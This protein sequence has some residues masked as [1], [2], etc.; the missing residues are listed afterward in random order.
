MKRPTGIDFLVARKEWSE[1]RFDDAL[2][3]A[4][5]DGQVLFRVDRFAITAN[6]ITYALAGD[7]LG[8]WNF[9]PAPEAMGRVPAMG[10]ADVIASRHAD[11]AEGLRCFGF[12]PMSRYLVIEPGSVSRE[13]IMDGAAHRAAL[14]PAYN[15]YSIATADTLYEEAQED[16]L[17]LLRGLFMTSFLADDF[18]ASSDYFGAESVLISSASSKTSIALGFQVRQ[19]GRAR[20]L[21]LTSARNLEFT[22]ALGCYDE[23]LVYDDIRTLN[24]ERPAIFVDMAGNKA[25]LHVIHEHWGAKLGHSCAIGM[26]HWQAGEAPAGPLSG[27]APEF[28][29]APGRIQKRVQDW[30]PAGFQKRLAEAWFRFRTF[31]AGWLEIHRGYGKDALAGVW[32]ATLAGETDPK[33]GNILSLFEAE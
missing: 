24:A 14:A 12:Y 11:V 27:P 28:F 26:T 16:T 8:Y 17:M 33:G 1:T 13:N 4:L 29:F 5:A 18:L 19:S 10:F 32:Q 7:M 21:G 25:I 6:N 15:Q 2:V 30:G 3:P 23:V 31:T 22:R 9:F 20:A